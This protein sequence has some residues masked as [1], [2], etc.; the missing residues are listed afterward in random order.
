[1]RPKK[2]K[3]SISFFHFHT[4]FNGNVWNFWDRKFSKFSSKFSL[5]IVWKLKKWDRKISIFFRSQNFSNVD[6]NLLQL[7][8]F[9]IKS[10]DFF[11]DRCSFSVRFECDQPEQVW[12]TGGRDKRVLLARAHFADT[13]LRVGATS[14]RTQLTCDLLVYLVCNPGQAQ[15]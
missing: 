7:F 11:M 6:F 15:W 10:F 4:I 1:M 14:F 8:S 2:S 5:K 13:I 12:I 3:F 9:S